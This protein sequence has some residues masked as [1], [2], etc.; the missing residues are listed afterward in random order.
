MTPMD[1]RRA[2]IVVTAPSGE[3]E[4]LWAFAEGRDRYRLD[5]IPL[6]AF[7]LSLGDVVRAPLID[8]RPA[9]AEVLER[10]GHSTYRLALGEGIDP[11]G[12]SE[13]V[14]PLKTLGCTFERFTRRMMGVDIPPAVDIY[15]AYELIEK[16]MAAGTWDFDEANVEHALK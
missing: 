10:S 9:F 13:L 4:N 16:G 5:N 7:G 1:T 8:G 11:D 6:L 14:S 12:F 2:K 3:V 15:A